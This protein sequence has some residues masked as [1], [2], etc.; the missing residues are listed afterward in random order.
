MKQYDLIIIGTGSAMNYIGSILQEHP[1]MKLAVIDKDDPGGICLTRGCIPSKMLLYPAELVRN[2]EI[3]RNFGIHSRIDNIDFNTVMERMRKSISSDIEMIRS[4]LQ[5]TE[6][7]DY[8]PEVAEFISPYTLK[9]GDETITA[10][11]IFLCTGSKTLIPPIKGL[12]NTEYLTSDTVLQMT[13]LP[14]SIVIIGAGYI[15]AEYGHF[16]S[17]MGSKVTIIGRG[18]RVLSQEEPEISILVRREMEQYMEILTGY[19]VT[20]VREENGKKVVAGTSSEDGSQLE[21]EAEAILVATGRASNSDILHP[22]KGNV[23]VDERGWIKVNEHL[24]TT[25]PNVWAFGDSNGQYLFKHVGNHESTVVYRN[26][27][28]KH[29]VSVDYHAVPHAVFSWPEIAGLG[30]SENAAIEHYGEEK[31]SIGFQP[32]EGTGKGLAMGLKNYFVKVILEAE[33]QKILGAHIIGPEASVLI[34]E[35][36]PLMY[37]ETQN[38]YPLIYSMDIHPSL[39]EVIK[40]AVNSQYTV[41]EYHSILMEMNLM[42]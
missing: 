41:N 42:E 4:G 8:Y 16:F 27:I 12:E 14:N 18:N 28:L 1:E 15:A 34:H 6:D 32:F 37:T 29:D 26:A 36:I 19:D 5:E 31:I 24:E 3:A 22:E 10:S 2:I 25:S 23:E 11:M 35:F 30:M 7:F 9:V 39:S 20:E 38:V 17:A 40:R 33:S 21:I 13:S